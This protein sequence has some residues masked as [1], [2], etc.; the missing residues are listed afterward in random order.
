ML[1]VYLSYI[2]LSDTALKKTSM[3]ISFSVDHSRR[4]LQ[5]VIGWKLWM[6][7]S[8]KKIFLGQTVVVS[9]QME[10]QHWLRHKKGFQAEVQVASH[11]NFIHFIIHRQA[12]P[13]HD[14]QAE[15]HTVVREAVKV[16]TFVKACRLNPSLLT[17]LCEE[18]Q[19]DHITS[20]APVK[21]ITLI[22]LKVYP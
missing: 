5:E 13:S 15:L 12:V 4:W 22:Q 8:L 2:Y 6:T 19:A 18:I 3:K 17:V 20:S 10:Q 11:V 16:M 9:V 1:Q 7:V 21:V 14:R